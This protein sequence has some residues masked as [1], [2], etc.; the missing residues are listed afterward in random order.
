MKTELNQKEKAERLARRMSR[1]VFIGIVGM[2]IMACLCFCERVQNLP[3]VVGIGALMVWGAFTLTMIMTHQSLLPKRMRDYPVYDTGC[4][5]KTS[6][7]IKYGEAA[8][9]VTKQRM[10]G[11]AIAVGLTLVFVSFANTFWPVGTAPENIPPT[12]FYDADGSRIM[13]G[14]FGEIA[15]WSERRN[16]WSICTS[17]DAY[18]PFQYGGE[19][20]EMSILHIVTDDVVWG[21]SNQEFANRAKH[22]ILAIKFN[23]YEDGDWMIVKRFV[24]GGAAVATDYDNGLSKVLD[25]LGAGEIP[26]TK[27]DLVGNT[28]DKITALTIV[29]NDALEWEKV[30][31]KLVW[32]VA[33]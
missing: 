12:L 18:G 23:H 4:D 19:I 31:G 21:E 15:Q 32:L 3:A 5:F 30:D 11:G 14:D 24:D 8:K 22:E 20:E 25:E 6:F 33:E 17:I 13:T 28:Q 7:T 27:H 2:I 16:E 26:Y 9:I 29:T 10:T 1:V